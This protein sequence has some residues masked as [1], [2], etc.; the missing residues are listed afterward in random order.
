M[1][2][3]V[4]GT[5]VGLLKIDVE[6]FEAAVFRGAAQMLRSQRPG[7]IMFESLEGRLSSEIGKVFTETDYRAF[8][9]AG[10][11]KPDFSRLTAQNLFVVPAERVVELE[12]KR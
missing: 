6:G 1:R 10:D 11:G 12:S 9:L 4:F 8:Q 2:W 7:L 3:R 5:E